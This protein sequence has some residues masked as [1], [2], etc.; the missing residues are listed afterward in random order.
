VRR[1]GPYFERLRPYSPPPGV[2]AT[3]ARKNP[4]IAVLFC[5]KLPKL[6]SSFYGFRQEGL[7]VGAGRAD[8]P[9]IGP[10]ANLS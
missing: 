10:M 7:K 5:A 9:P 8:D 3:D 4:F 1:P 2:Q 6:L